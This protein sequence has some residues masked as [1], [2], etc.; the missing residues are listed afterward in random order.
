MGVR[1]SGLTFK[2]RLRD[3]LSR[4]EQLPTSFLAAA[5]AQRHLVSEWWH[6]ILSAAI[7]LQTLKTSNHFSDGSL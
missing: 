7:R 1:A 2:N 4:V 5:G 3:A 6:C